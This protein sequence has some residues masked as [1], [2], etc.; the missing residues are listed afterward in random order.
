M[1]TRWGEEGVSLVKLLV[2]MCTGH[3][4]KWKPEFNEK[5]MLII[6]LR[7]VNISGKSEV[8]S[9]GWTAVPVFNVDGFVEHGFYQLPLYEGRG[10][11]DARGEVE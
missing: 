6:D 5:L 10:E 7:A 8:V 1:A 11:R 2:L 3:Q 9:Q 4:Q